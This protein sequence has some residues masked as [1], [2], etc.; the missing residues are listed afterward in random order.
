MP[1]RLSRFSE[2]VIEACWLAALTLVPLFFN[3][4][5][6]RVFEPD[7]LTLLRS[8]ALV[9]IAAWLVKVVDG[10]EWKKLDNPKTFWRFPLVI[11]VFAL[12]LVYLITTIF[13]ITPG[14]KTVN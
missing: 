13:S 4:Y 12:V 14:T 8:I 3:V 10:Q 1:N 2:A 5:S 6:E 9:M 11:P 7:K